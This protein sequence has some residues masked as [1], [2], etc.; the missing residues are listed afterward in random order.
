MGHRRHRVYVRVDRRWSG[1][2]VNPGA[3]TTS[4]QSLEGV[5][6]QLIAPNHVRT[7][8]FTNAEGRYEFPALQ[9]GAYTLRVATP[10]PFVAY[11][12]DAV[13]VNGAAPLDDIV[14][15]LLPSAEGVVL[16]G[17]FVPS[18]EVM[19]QLSGA[20]WLWNLPGTAEDKTTFV[21]ACGIGCHSYEFV[22]RNRYDERSWRLIIERMK[23][24]AQGGPGRAMDPQSEAGSV[25]TGEIE[26][27][28]KWVRT[29][30]EWTTSAVMSGSRWDRLS[31]ENR[32]STA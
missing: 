27:I 2:R 1:A 9:A 8:V 18:H 5:K 32:R 30:A 29:R 17:G 10:A 7:T 20:E 23:T 11:T 31:P 6:V 24:G 16:R 19:S 25:A 13:T 28:A 14:L 15:D 22:F 4:G 21:K 12:R 26:A 3:A